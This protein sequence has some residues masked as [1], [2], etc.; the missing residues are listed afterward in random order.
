MKQKMN[1]SFQN[2]E[3][4]AIRCDDY[5]ACQNI[6]PMPADRPNTGSGHRETPALPQALLPRNA[7]MYGKWKESKSSEQ[8]VCCFHDAAGILHRSARPRRRSI[9][10][11]A[12]SRNWAAQNFPRQ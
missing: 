2:Q 4:S 11:R 3:S 10:A 1:E 5:Y 7:D 8:I 12:C 9:S 6:W